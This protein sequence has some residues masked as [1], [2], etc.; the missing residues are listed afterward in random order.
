[1]GG[2]EP[3]TTGVFHH[4]MSRLETRMDKRFD[5]LD[6]RL[7]GHGERLAVVEAEQRA[8]R[9]AAQSKTRTTAGW[10]TAAAAVVV[11][12]FESVRALLRH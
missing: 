5:T 10:S 3:L 11:V 12:V 9:R 1:M 2:N 8:A 6:V 4:T 7:D